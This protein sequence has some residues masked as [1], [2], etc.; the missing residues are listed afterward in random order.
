M[1]RSYAADDVPTNY[2]TWSVRLCKLDYGATLNSN[3]KRSFRGGVLGGSIS[4]LALPF[5]ALE[6]LEVNLVAELMTTRNRNMT[7]T[8]YRSY[9]NY[10]GIF[11]SF[12]APHLHTLILC[13]DWAAVPSHVRTTRTRD[14][15]TSSNY[16]Q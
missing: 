7:R 2:G 5:G 16:L 8:T 9:I 15:N 13:T 1:H 10:D 12:V 11:H 6:T 4:L 3:T 14:D